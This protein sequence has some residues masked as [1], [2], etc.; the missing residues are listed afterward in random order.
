MERQNIAWLES[1]RGLACIIVVIAHVISFHPII[2]IYANG[3]GKI[4]VWLFFI[5]SSFL[6]I[7]HAQ[8]R[9][10][11]IKTF[12][13]YYWNKALRLYPV[14]IIG[15]G[16][17]YVCGLVTEPISIIRHVLL[18]DGV[19]HF[20]YMS[21]IIRFYLIAPVLEWLYLKSK[22]IF[23][24][25]IILL[26]IGTGII[27]PFTECLVNSIQLVW[28]FPVFAMGMLLCILFDYT[29]NWT[30]HLKWD[31]VI[32]FFYAIII[33]LT[34]IARQ[35]LFRYSPGSFL[36]NKYL[37]L[38]GIWCIILF[39]ISKG[40]IVKRWLI[41]DKLL[42]NIGKISYEI[43]VLH[44]S[45]LFGLIKKG[46]DYGAAVV[47]ALVISVIMSKMIYCLPKIAQAKK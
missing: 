41:K 36:Q 7:Y 21:V 16:V 45:I 30:I 6:L 26:G 18:L 15:I 34:P 44:Y 17:A 19:G 10:V 42:K 33:S 14:Y 38:G 28:Y 22:R 4:G 11:S 29:K 20:W 46:L 40:T 39:G 31:I 25:V 47:V 2:G 12:L 3:C 35:L 8:N 24:L 32:L 1:M 27:F 43:Y 37:F 23:V 9:F 5:M 13:L